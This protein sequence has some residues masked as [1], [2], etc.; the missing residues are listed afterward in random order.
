MHKYLCD[1]F[2]TFDV[3]YPNV[4]YRSKPYLIK[5]NLFVYRFSINTFCLVCP[6]F[7]LVLD[8]PIGNMKHFSTDM[9]STVHVCAFVCVREPEYLK[10]LRL[11]GLSVCVLL[12]AL[13][14]VM[15]TLPLR[16]NLRRPTLELSTTLTAFTCN[17]CITHEHTHTQ[18][19]TNVKNT[20]NL[21]QLDI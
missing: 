6:N 9:Y 10:H 11:A 5:R 15:L 18:T 14:A 4:W 12:S 16:P 8:L 7:W 13:L 20:K 21:G 3:F 17:I 1:F 19:Y 2:K